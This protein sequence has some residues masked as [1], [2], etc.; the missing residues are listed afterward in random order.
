MMRTF[1]DI[2]AGSNDTEKG[3]RS[4]QC[5]IEQVSHKYTHSYIINV[6]LSKMILHSFIA[7][8]FFFDWLWKIFINLNKKKIHILI[9]CQCIFLFMN[10]FFD[11]IGHIMIFCYIKKRID[12]LKN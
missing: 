5:F 12:F 3:D 8:Q 4:V 7:I 6:Y 9:I 10:I 1:N 11:F 2:T